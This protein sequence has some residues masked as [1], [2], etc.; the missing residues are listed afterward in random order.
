MVLHD[1]E[2]GIKGIFWWGSTS[3][4]GGEFADPR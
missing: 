3:E 4:E 2:K 1:A